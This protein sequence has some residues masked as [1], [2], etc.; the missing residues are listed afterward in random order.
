M[1]QQVYNYSDTLVVSISLL[2]HD[3]IKTR[4]GYAYVYPSFYIHGLVNK[5]Y[6][7]PYK[8][9]SSIKWLK[10]IF[11]TSEVYYFKKKSNS[12]I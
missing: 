10:Y 8:D 5:E 6:V 7:I 9:I 1:T 4:H 11:S 3:S 2:Q 12:Y